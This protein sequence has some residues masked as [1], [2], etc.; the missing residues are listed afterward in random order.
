MGSEGVDVPL[1]PVHTRPGAGQQHGG[2][3]RGQ[4]PAASF[5]RQAGWL[6][7][8]SC[9]HLLQA[10][11]ALARC[12]EGLLMALRIHCQGHMQWQCQRHF[13]GIL[14]TIISSNL[15]PLIQVKHLL[16]V[17][18]LPEGPLLAP[19]YQATTPGPWGGL[20]R[21]SSKSWSH[22]P[23]PHLPP[24]SSHESHWL[25]RAASFPPLT[26]GLAPQLISPVL[27]G[28]TLS[29]KSPHWPCFPQ[30]PS[31]NPQFLVFSRTQSFS[32]EYLVFIC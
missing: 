31:T 7:A 29:C 30:D 22:P 1:K 5:T 24:L 10:L 3:T 23:G 15:R 9:P 16:V 8:P 18:M 14:N 25:H 28:L 11:S 27:P 17:L 12:Q 21:G 6:R 4:C 32:E 13:G 2:E 26:D 19:S 20:P